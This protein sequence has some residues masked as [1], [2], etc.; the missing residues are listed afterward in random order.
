MGF[1]G[2]TLQIPVERRKRRPRRRC[3]SQEARSWL[4]AIQMKFFEIRRISVA[5]NV[6]SETADPDL[7]G[8][9][10][11]DQRPGKP[12]LLQYVFSAVI[13]RDGRAA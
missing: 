3:G 11:G 8:D 12:Y 13:L 9:V 6:F 4:L 5:F 1:L 10:E 2:P 7:R